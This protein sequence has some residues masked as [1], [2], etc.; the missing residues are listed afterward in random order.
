ML[1]VFENDKDPKLR[2]PFANGGHSGFR[3][4]AAV[5]LVDM[6]YS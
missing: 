6:D 1:M 2:V 4:A 3:S 5:E